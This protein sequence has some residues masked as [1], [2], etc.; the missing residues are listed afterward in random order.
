VQALRIYRGN[1]GYDMVLMTARGA[2]LT[3]IHLVQRT[4]EGGGQ[5]AGNFGAVPTAEL[6]RGQVK[7]ERKALKDFSNGSLFEGTAELLP[8]PTTP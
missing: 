4:A 3:E 2:A 1:K 8:K 6:L 5:P 7:T